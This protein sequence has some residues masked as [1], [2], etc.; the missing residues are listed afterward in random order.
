MTDFK[1]YSELYHFGIKGMHWGVRRYQNPD[2][3]LTEEGKKHKSLKELSSEAV[4]K[5]MSIDKR[6]INKILRTSADLRMA[7]SDMNRSSN[8]RELMASTKRAQK[9]VKQYL[10]EY[11]KKP[12]NYAQY[13]NA[14]KGAMAGAVLGV[15][16]PVVLPLWAT[17][18]AGYYIG[19]KINNSK[20]R[21]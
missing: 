5:I 13:N 20:K 8:E 6:P 4:D 18:P 15:A 17:I 2:G 7:Y 10:K 14:K 16:V 11:G 12:L 19:S 9:F 3:S 21:R 1:I